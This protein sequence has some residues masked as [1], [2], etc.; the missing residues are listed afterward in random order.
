[1]KFILTESDKKNTLGMYGL[2]HEAL[3]VLGRTVEINSD[4]TVTINDNKGNPQTI[5]MSTKLGNINVVN[6]KIG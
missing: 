1:M 5:R 3:N 2:V 6:I 4:G